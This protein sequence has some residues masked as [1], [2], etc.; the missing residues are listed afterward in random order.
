MTW[1]RVVPPWMWKIG[2]GPN[3]YAHRRTVFAL[4][5]IALCCFSNRWKAIDRDE[6]GS[7][8]NHNLT[9][10][11]SFSTEKR[12][13]IVLYSTK[14]VDFTAHRK[15]GSDERGTTLFN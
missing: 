5:H 1:R 15:V 9:A 14:G 12:W 8:A 7:F 11:P 2:T 10:S 4:L 6:K 13:T 3:D